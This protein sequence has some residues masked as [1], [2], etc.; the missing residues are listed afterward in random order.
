MSRLVK[1]T[2]AASDECVDGCRGRETKE[3]DDDGQETP[4]GGTGGKEREIEGWWERRK[5]GRKAE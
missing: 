1:C 3:N 4:K 2:F 5:K